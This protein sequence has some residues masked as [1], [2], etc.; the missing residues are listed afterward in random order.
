MLAIGLV[1][2]VLKM[3]WFELEVFGILS[4]YLNHLYWLYKNPRP[5]RRTRPR[6][7]RISRQHRYAVFL[8]VDLPH[9][10]HP[11]RRQNRLPGARFHR[12][13]PPQHSSSTGR[14]EVPV[15]SAASCLSGLIRN[16]RA[17]IYLRSASHH[18]PPPPRLH[19]PQPARRRANDRCRSIPLLRQRR[20]L[21][22][23]GRRR[24]F[25]FRRNHLRRSRLP[26]RRSPNRPAC[27][28]RSPCLQLP[29]AGRVPCQ[30]RGP[31]LR[32][33]HSFRGLWRRSLSQLLVHRH[34]MERIFP[35]RSRP[36]P[37]D[38]IPISRPSPPPPLPGLS[39][40]RIGLLSPSPSSCSF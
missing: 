1:T 26:P 19:H 22:L 39:F 34:A 23:A 32:A 2:I 8:L 7:P 9:F 30:N 14:N 29:P 37:L 6:L 15:R 33:R 13:R 35:R 28:H 12:R 17:R 3:G 10:L 20:R 40:P 31:R 38:V 18:S 4:S 36:P 16:R 21:P 11:A 25:S 24:S 27:R 5:Q